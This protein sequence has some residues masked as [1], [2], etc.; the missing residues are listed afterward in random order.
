MC[1]PVAEA[2]SMSTLS[3]AALADIQ[4]GICPCC[5]AKCGKVRPKHC[6]YMHL[7]RSNDAVHAVWKLQHFAAVFSKPSATRVQQADEEQLMQT[8]AAALQQMYTEQQL[9]KLTARLIALPQ[10]ASL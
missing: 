6:L 4:S 7:R 5:A 10:T 2:H 1:V 9:T 8:L 3:E